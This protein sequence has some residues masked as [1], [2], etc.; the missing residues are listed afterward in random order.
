MD[1]IA[2]TAECCFSYL[3]FFNKGEKGMTELCK[4][5]SECAHHLCFNLSQMRFKW[6]LCVTLLA[7]ILK[8][9]I[10]T[11]F[12]LWNKFK[13]YSPLHELSEFFNALGS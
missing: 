10:T 6:E 3:Y 11:I 9:S 1:K 12:M 7:E 5:Q 2:K 13:D 8:A 4:S